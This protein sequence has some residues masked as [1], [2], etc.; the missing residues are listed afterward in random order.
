MKIGFIYATTGGNTR[1]VCQ[2][3]AS[4]LQK[5]KHEVKLTRIEQAKPENL[6]EN[7]LL[8]L[9]SPTYGHGQ[10]DPKGEKHLPKLKTDLKG[11]KVAV[12]G[13]GDSKYDDDYNVESAIILEEFVKA[14][15]G[16]IVGKSLKINK[17]P[18]P[19][20]EEKVGDWVTDLLK[21]IEK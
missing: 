5:Q 16:E 21:I 18:M 10:L 8:V 4:L 20:V 6:T 12:I 17:Q 3:A 19:Q 1:L 15:N 7:D 13:L 2:W 14:N 9:A 11:K